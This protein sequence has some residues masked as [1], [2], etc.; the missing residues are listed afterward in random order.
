M[1][2]LIGARVWLA[3]Q[4]LRTVIDRS[5]GTRRGE[6]V[7]REAGISGISGGGSMEEEERGGGGREG[8]RMGGAL[9]PP[10]QPGA[11]EDLGDDEFDDLPL[12]LEEQLRSYGP[13]MWVFN[14]VP[15]ARVPRARIGY[16]DVVRR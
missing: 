15:G 6:G 16:D 7:G 11:S 5:P 13:E 4:A 1:Y 10:S 3:P 14:R 12:E 8:E 2:A 9:L